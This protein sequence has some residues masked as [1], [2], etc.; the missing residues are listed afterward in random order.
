MLCPAPI[1][2]V[3]RWK[4]TIEYDGGRYSGWQRQEDGVPTVQQAV[5]D[6][7]RGFSGRTVTLHA[8]G[9]TDAGVHA[10]GQVA[11]FDLDYGGRALE[12]DRLAMALN[13]HLRGHRIGIVAAQ[14][15][16]GDFHARYSAKDKLY[17]YRIVCRSAPPVLEAGRVWHCRKALDAAAMA[18]A[19]RILL[20]NH[21][22]STFRDSQ[23]QAKSPV[24]TLD[25]LDVTARSCDGADGTEIRVEAQ[26]RSFLHH[27]VRNM[28][29]SLVKVGEG[30]W[31]A[32]DLRTALEARD[33]KKGG[34]TAPAEGLAL[35]RVDY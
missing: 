17:L 4:L 25:R 12:G 33:R 3:T 19:A 34:Q 13:A 9:R 35:V 2:T 27:Q 15:V 24:R 31:S 7:V 14:A 32:D 11:H 18:K 22:F 6:A 10:W 21:D 20:G 29:G 23:C 1:M 26:A 5:E 28:V 16:S 30:K 8:A